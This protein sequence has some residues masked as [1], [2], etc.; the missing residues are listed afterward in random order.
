MN[1]KIIGRKTVYEGRAFSV[2]KVRAGL[3]DGHEREYDLVNHAGSVTILPLDADGRIWFVR[4]YR[5]GAQ[6]VLLELPAGV[7]DAEE[8]P[9]EGAAREVRE[10][11]GLAAGKLERLGGFYLAPGYSSEFMTVFL[12]TELR[13]DPLS[14]DADEFLQAEAIPVAEAFQ[15]VKEG[16]IQD[17]K[18]LATL[19]LARDH[20]GL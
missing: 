16:K 13:S 11:T 1:F 2:E 19:M 6:D 5:L 4:Q 14:A 18:T 3:P 7:L 20:L 8:T 15:L 9:E 12:A 17:G 10:E